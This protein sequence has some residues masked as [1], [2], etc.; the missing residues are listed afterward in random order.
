V[1]G[2]EGIGRDTKGEPRSPSLNRR[3]V[4]LVSARPVVEV[5]GNPAEHFQGGVVSV[6]EDQSVSSFPNMPKKQKEE[7]HTNNIWEG[8]AGTNVPRTVHQSFCHGDAEFRPDGLD[9]GTAGKDV[10]V[11][12][13]FTRSENAPRFLEGPNVSMVEMCSCI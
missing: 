7:I 8:D 11:C 6:I 2:W 5:L 4:L 10:C 12:F 1:R 9:F 3:E 13:E